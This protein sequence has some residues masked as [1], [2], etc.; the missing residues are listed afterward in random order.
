MLALAGIACAR[1]QPPRFAM[2]WSLEELEGRPE[3]SLRTSQRFGSL[4][5]MAVCVAGR[6]PD[7]QIHA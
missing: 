3:I 2:L 7:A 6:M 5:V 1:Q 4:G